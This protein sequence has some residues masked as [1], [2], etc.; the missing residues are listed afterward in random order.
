[1]SDTSRE[2]IASSSAPLVIPVRTSTATDVGPDGE[3]SL[4]NAPGSPSPRGFAITR[5]RVVAVVLLIAL[6]VGAWIA[7]PRVGDWWAQRQDKRA[8]AAMLAAVRAA[9]PLMDGFALP[10][11]IEGVRD[12]RSSSC[13]MRACFVGTTDLPPDEA[14]ALV[15]PALEARGLE[16][17]DGPTVGPCIDR[18]QRYQ[19]CMYEVHLNG[20]QVGSVQ[21]DLDHAM[22]DAI[23]QPTW[24][25]VAISQDW[26]ADS[27]IWTEPAPLGAAVERLELLPT[28]TPTSVR[29]L[30]RHDG[31]CRGAVMTARSAMA[32][33][34]LAT[35]IG[36][37][38]VELDL[39]ASVVCGSGA[40]R[41]SITFRRS[42]GQD[43]ILDVRLHL[44]R[45]GD[46]TRVRAMVHAERVRVRP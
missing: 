14:I 41:C 18:G 20:Q 10:A 24:V 13:A 9:G 2:S 40:E 15:T 43:R 28:G 30:D 16:V 42:I 1:M 5:R 39:K 46:R 37:R 33:D 3:P 44:H 38:T 23:G 27:G 4:A 17:R 34:Q 35:F 7:V 21:A 19:R 29:C 6:G 22:A 31:G 12:D 25:S 36:R 8:E 32:I 11:P 26:M 45:G